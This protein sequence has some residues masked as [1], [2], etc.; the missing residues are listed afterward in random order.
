MSICSR[1][2]DISIVFNIHIHIISCICSSTLR[3]LVSLALSK[4]PGTEKTGADESENE[5]PKIGGAIFT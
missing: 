5:P 3:S 1:Y 4:I 2:I